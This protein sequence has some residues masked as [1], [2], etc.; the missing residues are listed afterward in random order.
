[1]IKEILE[2]KEK[3]WDEK[4]KMKDDVDLKN[5]YLNLINNEMPNYIKNNF[6]V[7]NYSVWGSVGMGQYAEVPWV[8]II[9]P[10][11]ST[12]TQEGFY[13]V[14][15]FHPEGEGVYLTLNQGWKAI[16]KR[17]SEYNDYSSK[18]L[19]ISLSK[20][21]SDK[22]DTNFNQ[23]VFKYYEDDERNKKLGNNALGYSL[24][25]IYYKYYSFKELANNNI[26][27]DLKE[28][29]RL[30][31]VLTSKVSRDYYL[32]MLKTIEDYTFEKEVKEI[33]TKKTVDIVN[34]PTFIQKRKSSTT[35]KRIKDKDLKMALKEKELTGDKGE[36]IAMQYFQDLIDESS[37]SDNEREQFKSVLCQVSKKGHGNGYDIEAFDPENLIT[38]E[39]KFIEVKAT[40]SENIKEPFFL[41]L[42]EVWAIKENPG[43][44][45]IMRLYD[46]KNTPKAYFIDPY[47][48]KDSFDSIDELLETLFVTEPISYKIIGV[49]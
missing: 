10:E 16:G 33:N 37:L 12:T 4:L 15:L 41:S 1:M 17:A 30:Y 25:S 47:K 32:E 11:I 28:F 34:A 23:G 38:I 43:K 22:L 29:I 6:H 35:S 45:L 13:I 48:H 21:L 26:E 40:T 49:K 42:N 39:K 24:G 36:E 18:E 9:D 14:F 7:P 44:I 31:K 19:A 27:N 20:R 8:A 46:I 3:I 2:I 5:N